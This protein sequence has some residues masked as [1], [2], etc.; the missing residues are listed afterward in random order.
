MIQSNQVA[1]AVRRALVVGAITTAAGPAFA[2]QAPASST[3]GAV[4]ESIVVTGSRI[5]QP[6]VESSSPVTQVT[7]ADITTQG[8]TR[9]EDLINQLPQAFAA[10]NATVSNGS[11]GTA[12]V[13][14]RGLGS[15][16]TLVL[17]DGR[18]LPYG[19]VT[20]SA[21]DLNQ[22]PSQLIERVEVLTGGAS[23][24]YGSD[25]IAGVVNFITKR[26]FEGVEL[27]VGY[28]FFQHNNSFEGPGAVKLRDVIAGRAATNPAQF[29]LPDDNVTDGFGRQASILIGMNTDDG[30][31][32]FTAYATV[33]DFDEV[34]Q[35]DR[36]YSACALNPNPTVSFSCGGSSTASPG[37]FTDFGANTNYNFTVDSNSATPAWR[38]FSGATD[39]YNFGPTNFYLRPST[40][41]NMGASGHYELSEKADVYTQLM[42]T[43]Y[44]SVAQ[45][46]PGGIFIG[47]TSTI[48][49]DNPFIPTNRLGAIGCTPALIASGGSVPM[50]IGRRNTEGGGRQQDFKN[51][52]FRAVIGVRGDI[53]QGWDYDF[54]VQRAGVKADQLTKNYFVIS[55]ITEALDAVRLPNGTIQ[56][57]SASARADG[58]VPYNPFQNGGVTPESLEYLQAPG[59]QQGTIDQEIYNLSFTGDLGTYGIKLPTATDPVQIVV[60]A[61][62]RRDKLENETD[63]LLSTAALSGTG[64]A[65]IGIQGATTVR[66]YFMEAR[67]PLVQGAAFADD[68]SFDTAYRYSDYG[69]F[70]TNTYK[71]GLAW[72]PIE[73]VKL[74]GSYQK[75]VRAANIVE[76]FT[77]QGF[78]LF[79]IGGDPCG[80]GR[81]TANVPGN[82]S[83]AECIA[84][85]VP[86][87]FVGSAALDSPAGQY[88]FTQGGN[89]DLAPEE[90]ETF[91]AGIILQPRFLPNFVA[92][93]DY[94]DISVDELVS[95]FGAENTLRAC[96]D[97]NDAAA[98]SR[99]VRNQ[100][101]QLWL[102]SGNVLDTNI[103]IGGLETS[104]VDVNLQYSG[105]ELGGAGSL[106]FSLQGT[107]LMDLTTDPGPG[108][109]PYDCTGFF[110]GSCGTPNPEWR[111]QFRIT[112]QTPIDLD[113]ALTWRYFDGVEAYQTSP[114]NIDARFASQSY[115]DLAGT[116]A[117]SDKIGMTVGVNNVFDRDPPLNSGVGTTGNGN[118]YPQTYDAMGRFIFARATVG[119]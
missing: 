13:D 62:Y 81:G 97:N 21:A 85:G 10:Q 83:V 8:V 25:A 12:T 54:Y 79:D 9:V 101:G 108:L 32:N 96:Y 30:R 36:D 111:H 24:V 26:D 114:A 88:Q 29:Q 75:A 113:V 18:R 98:C 6:N 52:S 27:Q 117:F 49:C 77:A 107:Y 84:T 91:T 40:R 23:A 22:V 55:R 65:T 42:F 16:R 58:C 64:G 51:Q 48:N 2:Q 5:R 106:N 110:V 92:S 3:E 20:D 89:P 46:A 1:R 68:L 31:G 104:G 43:D 74:R 99:I 53:A 94:F 56:C 11:T 35:R 7:A 112:Y 4:L 41:Y 45:I 66:D 93:F 69:D 95:T 44:R 90:S 102:G 87:S 103:N 105:L 76:L 39:Q 33:E 60:G 86:A 15:S 37:R 72:A 118:T 67:V 17:V 19:G 70:N 38:N 59:L 78:N 63:A 100:L 71:F 57:R 34:L 47:D 115:I 61:E 14:L 73:D 116:Y 82:A 50:Y 28:D 119:F 80:P 109:E